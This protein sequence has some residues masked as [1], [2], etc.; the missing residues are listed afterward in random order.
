[1]RFLIRDKL[2]LGGPMAMGA[3]ASASEDAKVS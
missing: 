2:Q 3:A 1:M